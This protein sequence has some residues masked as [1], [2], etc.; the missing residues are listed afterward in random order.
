LRTDL[1]YAGYRFLP[2]EEPLNKAFTLR[3]TIRPATG[4]EDFRGA[5]SG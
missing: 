5:F 4:S 1:G 3:D 2:R